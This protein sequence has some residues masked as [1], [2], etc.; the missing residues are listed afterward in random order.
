MWLKNTFRRSR[1]ARPAGATQTVLDEAFLRRLE[2]LHLNAS[3]ML[4]GGLSGVHESARRLPAPTFSDHRS[5]S[6]SDD[7]RYVDWNAYARQEELFVKLGETEQ[8]V[9]I[10]LLLDRSSS[11]DYGLGDEHKLHY[12]KLLLGALGY[13]SLSSNDRLSA[14]TFDGSVDPAFGPQHSKAH[15]LP[16][17]RY[18]DAVKAGT[19]SRIGTSLEQYTRP[20]SGGLLVLISDLWGAGDI[21]QLLRQV[22]PPRWQLLV[23]HLLHRDELDPAFSGEL[24][25]QDSEIGDHVALDIDTATIDR[26]RAR[27]EQW[28]AAIEAACGRRGASYARIST[29]IPLERSVVP[30]LRQRLVLH[31]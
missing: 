7:L 10:H 4:R 29:A 20:R 11:M 18:A 25:L 31:G 3:R 1:S 24:E 17:L 28:C 2:R 5:Y 23:L 12:G 9:P 15:A 6:P 19:A 13:L 14:A 30:F 27:M 16:L 8:D 26:Y 22:Q 21:D